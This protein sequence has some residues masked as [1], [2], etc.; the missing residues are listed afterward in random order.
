MQNSYKIFFLLIS[1]ILFS[2][3]LF[4]QDCQNYISN[5]DQQII[6]SSGELVGGLD[7]VFGSPIETNNSDCAVN[8]INQDNG[9]PWARYHL[10]LKLSDF[11]LTPGDEL[12]VGIDGKN[13]SGYG[14]IEVN[15]NNRPNTSLIS[16]NFTNVWSRVEQTIIIPS[17][18]TLD[19]WLFS[20]YNNSNSGNVFYDN[21]LIEKVEDFKPFITTWKTDNT[22]ISDSN[23]IIIPTFQGEVYNYNVNWGDGSTS[24]NITGD[25]NHTYQV[26]GTY[27]ISI[28]GDFPRIFFDGSRSISKDFGKLI[29]IDQWGDVSWSSMASAF[30]GCFNL[31]M[32]AED[33]PDLNNVTSLANMFLSCSSLQ[34][35]D[36]WNKWETGTIDKMNGM[37]FFS[38]FNFNISDWDVSNVESMQAMFKLSPFNQNIGDWNVGNVST[39]DELFNDTPFNQ[40]ISTWDVSKVVSMV[41]MFNSSLFNQ[42]ISTWDVSKV[43]SMRHMF[44]ASPFDQNISEWNVSSLANAEF[45]FANAGLSIENYDLLLIGWSR[46]TNLKNGVDF[47]AGNSNYCIATE[48]HQKLIDE[49]YW[50]ITDAGEN[51]PTD[52]SQ[53]FIT[54]WKTDNPGVSGPNQI[55]I[56]IS[57]YQTYDYTVDWGDGTISENVSGLITH[58]YAASGTYTVSIIGQFPQIYFNNAFNNISDSKKILLVNQWGDIQWRSMNNAFSG[59]ENLDVV[60]TDIPDFSFVSSMNGMF[61]DAKS[62]LFNTS[63]NDWDVGNVQDMGNMF[64]YASVFNQDIGTWNTSSVVFMW[65]MFS[66]A[67]MFNQNIGNWDTSHVSYIGNMF[68][69]AEQFNQDIGD[70]NLENVTEMGGMFYNARSFN[71]DISRWNVSKVRNT[72]SMF[73]FASAFNQDLSQW[74][75]S[76]VE[77]MYNMFDYS[78][79]STENYD[80]ALI[81]WSQLPELK[82]DVSL[83][84]EQTGFC[85]SESARQLLINTYNWTINDKGLARNCSMGEQTAFVTTWKTD[86]Q[87]FS[88]DN[89]ITIP[90]YTSQQW[91]EAII[92]DYT[93]DWGDGTNDT[94]VTGDITHTYATPG[95]YTVSITGDFPR[96]Y[97]EGWDIEKDNQKI[98]TVEQWG[99][100]GWESMQGAFREC[101]NL[102]VVAEDI[103]NFT[104]LENM[105]SMFYGCSSLI[106]NETINQ[107]ETQNV[108]EMYSVFSNAT[109]FNQPIGAWDVGEVRAFYDMF[110][111]ATQFNQSLSSWNLLNAFGIS[112]MFRDTE[113]NQDISNWDV[114]NV[115]YMS[116]VFKSNTKFNQD[117]SSWDVSSVKDMSGVFNGA[118][119]FN[120][121]I[122]IWDV[123][124]VTYMSYLFNEASSFNQ[125][126][127]N[128]NIS[129]VANMY[130]IFDYSGISNDNYDAIL[131]GWEQ[132]PSL[133]NDVVVS[134]I[135]KRF[136]QSAQARANIQAIYGW[137]FNDSGKSLNCNTS[138][139]RAF[140]TTWSV[141]S[142]NNSENEVVIPIYSEDVNGSSLVY[143][144][145]VN[146][147]D[148]IIE[149]NI[150]DTS[151]HNYTVSG[152]YQIEIIG[153]FPGIDFSEA[154]ISKAMILSIDQWGDIEWA[155]MESAFA[156]CGNLDVLAKDVPN[157]SNVTDA[158]NMFLNCESLVGNSKFNEWDVSTLQNFESMF[159]GTI[160]FNQ[161]LGKWNTSQV[162]NMDQ[163]FFESGFS[164]SLGTWNVSQVLSMDQMLTGSQLS[165]LNYDNTLVGWGRLQ[166]L[167]TNVVFDAGFSSYCSGEDARQLLIDSYNWT[168]TDN[169]KLCLEQ[170]AFVT[171]WKTDN[172]G[173][174]EDN[175]ISLPIWGGPYA[176]DWGDGTIESELYGEQIH[177]YMN[178]GVYTVS[179]SGEV[180]SIYLNS[181]TGNESN[182]DASKILEI[183]QWGAIQWGSLNEAFSGCENL[184]VTAIDIPD[185][186]NLTSIRNMFSSCKSLKGNESFNNW[187]VSNITA[188]NGL[189]SDTRLFNQSLLNWD[190][191]NV[192]DMSYLF[193]GALGYDQPLNDW[194]V[195]GVTNMGAMFQSAIFN[196]DISNWN[197][198]NV[199]NMSFMFGNS[200][201]FNQ[202]ISNWN[203][204]KVTEMF[205]MFGFSSFDQDLSTWDVSMVENMDSMFINSPLSNE[206]YDNTLIGWS[207]LPFLQYNVLLGASQ[208]YCS[209]KEERQEIID[210]YGWVITDEGENCPLDFSNAFVTTWKTDNPGVSESNQIIIPTSFGND[211]D[212]TVD[213]GDDIVESGL[214]GDATHTYLVSGTYTVSIIGDFP[215]I[216]FN[217]SGDKDKILSVEQWGDIQWV[218]FNSAFNGCTNLDVVADDIPNS[219]VVFEWRAMFKN[220]SSLVGNSAFN[221]WDTG[222]ALGMEDMFSGATL[223]NQNI[224]NWLLGATMNMN[225][226]FEN[227]TSFN[228]P[229]NF[230][231][232]DRNPTMV[233]MLNGATSFNQDLSQMPR[234][235]VDMTGML[236]NSGMS[237]ENYDKTL[238]GWSIQNNINNVIF[239]AP[240]NHYCISKDSRQILIDE[241]GWV[242]TDAGENCPIFECQDDI[243]NEDLS[244]I[245]PS[246]TLI[247]GVDT[248]VGTVVETNNSECALIVGNIDNG[249]PWGR[250]RIAINLVDYGISTGD[251]LL[252]GIDGKNLTGNARI[253]VNRNNQPNTALISHNFNNSWSRYENTFTVPSELTTIDIWLFSNYSQSNLGEAVYDNLVVRN[254]SNTEENN[255]PIANAGN[256]IEVEDEDF[257]GI[258]TVLL[259]ANNSVDFDGDL[260]SYV[261]TENEAIIANGIAPEVSLSLGIHEVELTVT[262]N[263]GAQAVDSVIISVI[264]PS[265]VNCSEELINENL[266][267]VLS[268]G[269]LVG[270]VDSTFGTSEDTNNSQ[271]AVVVNNVDSGQPWGRYQIAINLLDYDITVGDEIYIGVDG[272]S[273]SGKARME[274]NRNNTQNTALGAKSFTNSWS[275]YETTFIVPSDLTTIDLWFFSNYGQQTS[276]SAVYDNL[277]VV[278]LSKGNISSGKSIQVLE[279]LND[280]NIFPN[281]ANIET[282]L[283]FNQP[284]T[285]GIIQIFDVTGRLVQTING[286]LIDERGAPLNVQEMPDGV[287]FVKTTDTTGIEFQQQMLIQRQ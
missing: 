171:T 191:S 245:L 166:N 229:L 165:T 29:S 232:M 269:T 88:N 56:P 228:Q 95:I 264:E 27:T 184:D 145:T 130:A 74:N 119:N 281:P 160:S 86:N 79:I 167:K 262:D 241:F 7:N 236:V 107:W 21:L 35:N 210:T 259:N 248:A 8:V 104:W 257:N 3:N 209:S 275:R 66:E 33:V 126:I 155:T 246:G 69:G 208:S 188:M 148:G 197:V 178:P 181:Y 94:N 256:D 105:S 68:S 253:E 84:A 59:C 207:K 266:N 146:W 75:I 147:G 238:V 214:S 261:W 41:D 125:N 11:G 231:G 100:Y 143:D 67:K 31:N 45:M 98:L 64:S 1:S 2:S 132:L 116:E 237:D 172:L 36:S 240:Q 111:G 218:D 195:S 43:V 277:E 234:I 96:I 26:P 278:N 254:L 252:I 115:E 55:T 217:A 187:D 81:A 47:N 138:E 235:G 213:W 137:T 37:F 60:A 250:Y 185:F 82:N 24:T 199:E 284:T 183:N 141:T 129:A 286:G 30:N 40:D 270:G 159:N 227:A 76:N 230:R 51:C 135:D 4:S 136:C 163:M 194:D 164:N 110:S 124:K 99:N 170:N 58:T 144:Y 173:K 32:E 182:S 120:K 247:G 273:T 53:G 206:N 101:I 274:I 224:N 90:T 192:T 122:S 201:S 176:V 151:S 205:Y 190:V 71:Q 54:T 91:E 265:T 14:R 154:G 48:A 117:I 258:E 34:D 162:N 211:Y 220:C 186:T 106:G 131:I 140:I 242:I 103:P 189:F 9:Q 282:T 18:E 77:Y 157:L 233:N 20:N 243:I 102:D 202:D 215:Q 50:N 177:S 153:T 216:F 85:E 72:G 87:G 180:S 174:T 251:E 223:F 38:D 179:I 57:E 128:W 133:R 168:I 268:T 15:Q 118:T 226:M 279:P 198:S 169:G 10:S 109:Q 149:N 121:D 127:G 61:L 49:N 272:K 123:S 93:I 112:G 175:Q 46:N 97:F 23:Q 239:D 260:V 12:R 78:G 65:G 283:S 196:Q 200:K 267:M 158:S 19:I 39:M 219:S 5:E 225:S 221:D 263:K 139:E 114:S 244:I 6:L 113:F 222:N 287:Y 52:F 271:C 152:E 62:L 161:I 25:G 108:R 150:T 134:A 193:S 16:Q 89:Q 42:D 44:N 212:Y 70:W 83:G 280:L 22:G 17:V 204:S 92:Y 80:T 276:G 142:L 13:D 73:Y 255:I 249:Q 63:I 285:V 28:S 156:N 203:V